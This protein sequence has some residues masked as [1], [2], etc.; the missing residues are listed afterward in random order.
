MEADSNFSFHKN[1]NLLQKKIKMVMCSYIYTSNPP[2]S[3]SRTLENGHAGG[4]PSFNKSIHTHCVSFKFFPS[5]V[6]PFT[7][8]LS[9]HKSA[10]LLLKGKKLMLQNILPVLSQ[11]YISFK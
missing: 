2:D 1:G 9:Y 7:A 10:E 5:F 8:V 4:F 11:L 3:C 6:I